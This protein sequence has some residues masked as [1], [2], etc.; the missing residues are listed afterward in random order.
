MLLQKKCRV[1]AAFGCIVTRVLLHSYAV[2]HQSPAPQS[3]GRRGSASAPQSHNCLVSAKPSIVIDRTR[4]QHQRKRLIR[5]SSQSY[6]SF[7][8]PLGRPWPHSLFVWWAQASAGSPALREPQAS[9]AVLAAAGRRGY[10]GLTSRHRKQIDGSG[11][12]GIREDC[13]C[14]LRL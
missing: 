13:C 14:R 1:F 3:G 7:V 4:E 11:Q 9:W 2:H 10:E 8:S 5:S 12:Y 6:T